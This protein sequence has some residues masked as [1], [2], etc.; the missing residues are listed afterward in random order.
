MDVRDMVGIDTASVNVCFDKGTFDAMI[1]GSPWSPPD[2]VRD[3]T[4]RYLR[5]VYRIL[6]PGGVFLWVTFRQPHFM[7]PLLSADGLF[8]LDLQV[9]EGSAASFE[10]YG[11]VVR[12]K[13][14]STASTEE[15]TE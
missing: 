4:G 9:L 1:H 14:A 12:K 10:Y 2:D 6:K 5:E 3:N 15:S 11:W 7:R 8:D 13:Q